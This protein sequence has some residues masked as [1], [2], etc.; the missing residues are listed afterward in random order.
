VAALESLAPLRGARVLVV[1]DN[2]LNQQVAIE[3]LESAGFQVELASDGRQAVQRVLATAQDGTP[4][5]QYL[6]IVLMDMQM[7]V[8][9]GVSA[10]RAI[11]RDARFAELPILAMTANALESDRQR[12]MDAGM[13]DFVTKPFEPD[14]LWGALATWIRPRAGLGGAAP[15]AAGLASGAGGAHDAVLLRPVQGLD[16]AVGLRRVLGRRELYLALLA[17][18]CAS[19]SDA[20]EA[21]R[22]ALARGDRESAER[23]AHTVKGVAGTIGAQGVAELAGTLEARLRAPDAPAVDTPLQALDEALHA[24]ITGLATVL[25]ANTAADAATR[26]MEAH[27]VLQTLTELLA[28]SD[29]EARELVQAEEDA[30]RQ[31]LGD[32]YEAVRKAVLDYDFDGAVEMLQARLATAD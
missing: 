32:A 6:D 11:R 12:C 3:L 1:E 27:A 5:P 21:I 26:N 23:V 17:K 22:A 25:P 20:A 9:D 28:D 14:A 7:P 30:L 4:G 29:P 2:T 8:M 13:Q 31:G 10:A 16:T 15:T 18:F 19:Q 24:L